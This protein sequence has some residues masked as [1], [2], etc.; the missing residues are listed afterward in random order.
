MA[1]ALQVGQSGLLKLACS[2]LLPMFVIKRDFEM[3]KKLA[4][5]IKSE[6]G[7]SRSEETQ[8]LDLCSDYLPYILAGLFL[9]DGEDFVMSLNFFFGLF[10]PNTLL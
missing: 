9:W 7:R 3:L 4:G 8:V 2:Y 1:V 10:N 6:I 5:V